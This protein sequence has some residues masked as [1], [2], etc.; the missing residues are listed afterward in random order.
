M[1]SRTLFPKKTECYSRSGMADDVARSADCT[2]KVGVMSFNNYS[3]SAGYNRC[4]E[5]KINV[6]SPS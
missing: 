5:Y 6:P 1:K 2:S 4:S 3:G